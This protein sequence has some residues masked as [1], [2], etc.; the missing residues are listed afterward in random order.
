MITEHLQFDLFGKKAFEKAVVCPPFR[1]TAVLEDEACFYFTIHGT[2]DMYS[3]KGKVT[4]HENEGVVMR[5]G[6]YLNGF[7]A[8]EDMEYCEVIAVHFYPNI[9]R[10]IYDKDLLARIGEVADVK[11]IQYK[12]YPNTVLLKNY[13]E[14]LQF[15]FENPALVSEELLKLKMKELILLLAKTDNLRAIKA[16]FASL[17][18]PL[19]IDLRA[20]IEANLY[21]NVSVEELAALCKMSLS[22]FKRSFTK[23]YGTSPARY[24]RERKLEKAA[25]LLKNTNLR[26]SDIAFDTGFTDL[27]HFSKTFQKKFGF[28]PT[29]FRLN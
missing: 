5:C 28:S 27:A 15:Y 14:S 29:N 26:I 2:V 16:L 1:F 22:S 10:S 20:V 12:K 13:I 8:T 21:H 23:Q 3:P 4:N 24:L 19:E 18:N 7:L 25:Q 17:F 9:L 11:P 6:T